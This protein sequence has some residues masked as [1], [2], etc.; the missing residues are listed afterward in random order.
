MDEHPIRKNIPWTNLRLAHD[1][2]TLPVSVDSFK[3]H[4]L[5]RKGCSFSITWQFLHQGRTRVMMCWGLNSQNIVP[6]VSNPTV[7]VLLYL[8]CT[9]IPYIPSQ[10]WDDYPQ[11]WRLDRPWHKWNQ[12]KQCT[13]LRGK[14]WRLL[15]KLLEA[16]TE[17]SRGLQR[18]LIEVNGSIF[19]FDLRPEHDLRSKK[20]IPLPFRLVIRDL[21]DESH[22]SKDQES[23]NKVPSLKLTASLP[24]KMDGK[25]R[26]NQSPFG[27]CQ[28]SGASC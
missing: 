22:L 7:G 20:H 28:C 9:R 14:F 25:G 4:D 2:P 1:S 16:A 6:V 17:T 13:I 8:L 15:N 3:G 24:L 11:L 27:N 12:P 19:V 18:V 21:T 10:G 23:H 26:W 5:M